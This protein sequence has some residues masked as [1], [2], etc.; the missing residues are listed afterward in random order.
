MRRF[1]GE[2]K[3]EGYKYENIIINIGDTGKSGST[4]N[5]AA[6]AGDEKAS[7]GL[8][9]RP[10]AVGLYSVALPGKSGEPI[11]YYALQGGE[12][13]LVGAVYP[14]GRR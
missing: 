14:T 5:T 7:Q 11:G 12:Q 4:G 1:F 6:E 8:F 10:V 9:L 13:C 2:V 3:E